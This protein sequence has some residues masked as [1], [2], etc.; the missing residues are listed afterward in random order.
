MSTEQL[1]VKLLVNILQ[2][3][4]ELPDQQLQ[5]FPVSYFNMNLSYFFLLE[6]VVVF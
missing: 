2:K 4:P 5:K 1:L 3:F 6:R